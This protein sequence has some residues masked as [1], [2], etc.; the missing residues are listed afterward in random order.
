[1]TQLTTRRARLYGVPMD[2]GQ[3]RRG[4][5]MGPSAIRYAE[6][7]KRL[8]KLGV[9]I[10]DCGNVSVPVREQIDTTPEDGLMHHAQAVSDVCRELYGE[11]LTI[12]EDDAIGIFL[13]GDH[14]ISL[15]S[16]A[17]ALHRPQKLGV[18][19]VDAHGD[20]NTPMTTPSGNVHGMVVAALMGKCPPILTMGD[21]RLQPEQ[22]VYIGIRDLDMDEKIALRGAGV[23]IYT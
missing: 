9:E 17:A 3:N 21:L 16:V 14:S 18:L 6:L 13:G 7:Q 5:D 23:K 8:D 2:L 15:G 1:M 12:I 11:A 22:I 10:E 4:V 19:W 20:F